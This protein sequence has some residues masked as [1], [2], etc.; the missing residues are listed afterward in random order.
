MN[1]IQNKVSRDV[2]TLNLTDIPIKVYNHMVRM[3]WFTQFDVKYIYFYFA[4]TW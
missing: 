4:H 2:A 3:K 1:I